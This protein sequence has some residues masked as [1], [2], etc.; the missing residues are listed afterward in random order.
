[1][2]QKSSRDL[3]LATSFAAKLLTAE[4]LRTLFRP[5]SLLNFEVSEIDISSIV[6]N[7]LPC[8]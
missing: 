6:L 4:D 7:S 5:V 2:A 3:K 1:M 8:F